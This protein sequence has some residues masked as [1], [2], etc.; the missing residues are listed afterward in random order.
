M[1]KSLFFSIVTL[2]TSLANA[3]ELINV[4]SKKFAELIKAN[5]GIILDVRTFQEFSQGHIENSTLISI[6]DP[7]FVEKVKLLQKDKPIYVY[8]LSGS[9]SQYAANYLIKNGFAEV[10]N[11]KRGILE[12]QQLGLPL[13][14]SEKIVATDSKVFTESEFNKI[15]SS[16]KVVLI[17]FNASWCAPCKQML[18]II[19]QLQKE[20]T[21]K[22]TI[23]KVDI[24]ANK[25]IKDKYQIS[26][27][28]GFIL[29][30]DGKQVWT[31]TGVI[32]YN[33]L[34]NVINKHL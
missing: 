10:Y 2:I 26:S 34:R 21:G 17:D 22:A 1:K 20:Y 32:S 29:F 5:Q 30:K 9:R 24:V 4:D 18:P 7:G 28:P 13:M 31:Y 27:I 19:D 6:N 11:L 33:D 8:C 15:L 25:T 12:W 14:Q 3:Q 16:K 23:E